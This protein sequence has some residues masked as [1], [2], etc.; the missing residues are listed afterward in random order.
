MNK[1]KETSLSTKRIVYLDFLRAAMC[2]CVIWIHVIYAE[3]TSIPQ[4]DWSARI[5]FGKN[6][7]ET[8]CRLAVPIFVTISGSLLLRK[9]R[10]LSWSKIKTSIIR[11]MLVLAIFGLGY[12]LIESYL[13]GAR[14]FSL[15]IKSIMNL[16]QGKSWA[17]MWYVYMLIGLY[18]ITSII[19]AFTDRAERKEY[20]R[21]LAVLFVVS[22][23]IPTISNLTG[24]NLTQ[25]YL[26]G[27]LYVFYY[28]L[29]QYLYRFEVDKKYA[30]SFTVIGLIGTGFLNIFD[31]VYF[32]LEKL[33]SVF[34]VALVI[35][36]YLLAKSAKLKENKAIS[37]ISKYSFGIYLIHTFWLNILNKGI[38]IYPSS[39]PVILGEFVVFIYA[40]IVSIL[41]CLIMYRLPVFKKILK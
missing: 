23:V 3:A 30:I 21:T 20:F 10:E 9:E 29:G 22:S 24:L 34:M 13:N 15:A 12:C 37:F 25:F 18:A 36:V 35:G 1:T 16:V 41:S 32:D 39:M 6:I 33:S 17:V 14:G 8:L 38:G 28:M 31:G 5:I 26:T 27:S 11:M 2:L 4:S 19:K 40:L 7:V